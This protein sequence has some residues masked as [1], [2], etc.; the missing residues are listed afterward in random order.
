MAYAYSTSVDLDCKAQ[1]DKDRNP[2]SYATCLLTKNMIISILMCTVFVPQILNIS[3]RF[4]MQ[5]MIVDKENK[6]RETL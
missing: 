3:I 4:I 6:V 5:I 1:F 2:Y